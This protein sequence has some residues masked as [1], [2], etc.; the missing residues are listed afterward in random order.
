[1]RF[2]IETFR[3]YFAPRDQKALYL[4]L[5]S[6]GGVFVGF[7]TS[8]PCD[9]LLYL[10]RRDTPS[11]AYRFT[12]LEKRDKAIELLRKD[13]YRVLLDAGYEVEIGIPCSEAICIVAGAEYEG[14]DHQ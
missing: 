11:E 9:P 3:R 12:T 7:V 5:S 13:Q 14:W 8:T 2:L 6:A 10:K 4:T 1:M